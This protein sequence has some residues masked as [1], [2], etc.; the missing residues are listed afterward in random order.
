[1]PSNASAVLREPD[2]DALMARLAGG[3]RAAFDPLYAALRPRALRLAR[4]HLGPSDAADVA[5]T[6][7][8]KVFARASEFT[9]GRPCLPWFYAVVA[10]EIRSARR[11][12][13][14]AEGPREG[15]LVTEDDAEATFAR[16]E[17]ERA[18]E[19]ALADL[20][21][22]SADAVGALLGRGPRPA[23][24]APAF[25]KRISRA[26]ERL[27]LLLGEHLGSF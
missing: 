15:D 3:E 16:R 22:A 13:A 20:D 26:Y 8:L 12:P 9:P 17:L 24:S 11:K 5:Q 2:L 19:L 21:G 18:L 10:N 23:V 7:L 14:V 27:R 1:L 4:A 25:R 6:S